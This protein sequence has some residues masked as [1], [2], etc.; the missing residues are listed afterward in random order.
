MANA[1][2][3]GPD[4]TSVVEGASEGH[5][6][7][8]AGDAGAVLE[9]V[10]Y[11]LASTG[12]QV[13]RGQI[14]RAVED[15]LRALTGVRLGIPD[16]LALT[17]DVAGRLGARVARRR[18]EVAR[19]GEAEFRSALPALTFVGAP[20]GASVFVVSN[21]L[22][23]RFRI[24]E[25]GAEGSAR[26]LTLAEAALALGGEGAQVE[27]LLPDGGLAFDR[28]RAEHPGSGPPG[29]GHAM[30]PLSRLWQLLRLERDD[31]WVAVVFAIGVGLL[32]LATPLG[33][34]ALVNTV[35]FGALAQPLLVL[36]L[37]VFAGLAFAGVLRA[38]Q[39]WTIER[40]QERIFVRVTLDLATR[41][42]RVRPEVH[43]DAYVP[44]LVN[45]FF[46]VVT[47]QKGAAAVVVEGV[48]IALQTILGMVLLGF[49]HPF[50][51][52]YTV[53][54][55]AALFVVVVLLGR[56]ATTTAIYES[57]KKFAIA[58]WLEQLGHRGT[59]FRSTAG[60]ELAETRARDLLVAWLAA[61]RNHF[62]V[63]FRQTIGGLVL[64]AVASAALLG[65]GGWLVISRQ[66]TLGQLVA[67]EL[68]VSAVVSGFS[69]LGKTFETYYDLVASVDKVGHLIDLP[70][71]PRSGAHLRSTHAPLGLTIAHL[72]IATAHAKLDVPT[73][74]LHGGVGL[75][76]GVAGTGK[77][78]LAD[79]VHGL[80]AAR[81]GRIELDGVSIDEVALGDLRDVS[82]LV[83]GPE[84]FQGSILENVAAGRLDVGP[85]EARTALE[86]V[87]AWDEV[88]RL[89]QG[90][91][92]QI[93]TGGGALS[94]GL[95]L[96]V[97]VARALA[98]RPRLAIFDG[99]LDGF[100][101]AERARM[102]AQLRPRTTILV[103]SRLDLEEIEPDV[104]WSITDGTLSKAAPLAVSAD[105]GLR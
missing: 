47:V 58:G 57:K 5:V 26:E 12:V 15:G 103:F 29:D 2:I 71:E 62:S 34:Q 63:V 90:L 59:A 104:V 19:L 23:G 4:E 64:Q 18:S 50:L 65:I 53:G 83:Q 17:T 46:D 73:L 11:L 102:L 68:I 7:I 70:I 33:V 14:R 93:P 67:A 51:L 49:Y 32:S 41:L 81:S 40:M 94:E 75:V 35:A 1:S 97:T 60:A 101:P 79:A 39:T 6:P 55:T 52:A 98:R 61:R 88:S 48:S 43:D 9:A 80:R 3:S 25:P 10:A 84:L 30:T 37:L 78:L 38:L 45:R 89:A 105:G 22:R 16:L 28:V 74:E 100:M 82:V 20:P 36:T 85:V 92:F 8:W 13:P 42:P 76:K 87:S 24:E 95:K 99:A 54:L 56:N 86:A 31:V 91:D 69:K 72:S 66:L 96:R 27:W 21:V 77:S 44:E